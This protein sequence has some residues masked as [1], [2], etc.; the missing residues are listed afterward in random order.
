MKIDLRRGKF[1]RM[2]K[3]AGSTVTVHSGAVWITEQDNPHDVML[4]PGQS[5]TLG[6]SGLTLV[7]AFGD[8]SIT[9]DNRWERSS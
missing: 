1:L 2:R 8:A 3:A 4:Q 9:V 7:E 6:R 5:F